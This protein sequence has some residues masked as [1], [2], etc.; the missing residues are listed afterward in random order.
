[1]NMTPKTVQDFENLHFNHFNSENFL[2]A[3]D[4]SDQDVN[5]FNSVTKEHTKYFIA[6]DKTVE[7]NSS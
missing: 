2:D 4:F 5:F 6:D 1:M 3:S 7:L